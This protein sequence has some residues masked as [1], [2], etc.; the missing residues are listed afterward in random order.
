MQ[1]NRTVHKAYNLFSREGLSLKHLTV[2]LLIRKKT[3][4]SALFTYSFTW[5]P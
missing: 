4:K 3:N 1:T 2:F 5:L